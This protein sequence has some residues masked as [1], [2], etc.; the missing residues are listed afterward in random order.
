MSPALNLL[1]CLPTCLTRPT[2]SCPGTIGKRAGRAPLHSSRTWWMSEWQIPQKRISMSTSFGPGSRRSM[3]SGARGLVL[4]V[5]AYAGVFSIVPPR[6]RVG[7]RAPARG[8]ALVDCDE[9]ARRVRPSGTVGP[10]NALLCGTDGGMNSEPRRTSCRSSTRESNA[11]STPTAASPGTTAIVGGERRGA[12]GAQAL[13][14]AYSRALT[15]DPTHF[16]RLA[17]S[18]FGAC[19]GSPSAWPRRGGSPRHRSF[20]V[21]LDRASRR[22]RPVPAPARNETLGGPRRSA[23]RR[24]GRL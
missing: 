23:E 6:V 18:Y 16:V 17:N 14:P 20:R 4:E 11:T 7:C 12:A 15:P 21:Q 1:T 5:A 19:D 2:I 3:V 24:D 22:R 9:D 13:P 8:C 10:C